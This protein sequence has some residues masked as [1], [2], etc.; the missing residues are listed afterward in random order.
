MSDA[1]VIVAKYP[2]AGAVKT[3]LGASIG[4][5]N[6][7][8][9]Y[10]AF[11]VDLVERFCRPQCSSLYHHFWSCP[12]AGRLLAEILGHDATILG[13]RGDN[14]AD[15][16][17]NIC[18]DMAAE[19]YRRLVIM[20]SDSPQLPAA[21]VQHGFD[22]LNTRDVV[23]GPAEDCGYYLI[24]L[25]LYPEPPD[26]FRGIEMSTP[27]VLARTVV[28]AADLACSVALL[29]YSFD[30]DEARDLPRLLDVLEKS[31]MDAAPHTVRE[32]R[33]LISMGLSPP[34]VERLDA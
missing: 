7:A 9:L 10:R 29:P 23:L 33:R 18:L 1:L 34:R 14:F 26:L 8:H 13:Q 27:A 11:L 16:L 12:P 24:G 31:G 2:E 5:E 17:F 32:L 15:R 22:A 21:V 25:H 3:R 4:Y 28:R 6:A 19:G 30:V 20:A